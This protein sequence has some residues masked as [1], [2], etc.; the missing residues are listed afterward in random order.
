MKIHMN[1]Y[2]DS[3]EDLHA[4]PHEDLHA[5]PHEDLYADP[6]VLLLWSKNKALMKR[7]GRFHCEM[8]VGSLFDPGLI[9]F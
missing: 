2:A 1:V 4:D 3:H 7:L 5:D 8:M 9:D 6:H